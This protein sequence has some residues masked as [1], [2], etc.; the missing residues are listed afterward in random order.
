M[1]SATDWFRTCATYTKWPQMARAHGPFGKDK[2][3][4]GERGEMAGV[5][6]GGFGRNAPCPCG[7][8]I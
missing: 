2:L 5:P 4:R 3:T 1:A 6:T 7:S 8:G